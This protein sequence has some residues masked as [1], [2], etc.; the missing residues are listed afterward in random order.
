MKIF[1]N[2]QIY[3]GNEITAQ[4]NNITFID[5][6]EHTGVQIFEW[7][8]KRMQG[9]QV[10]IHVFCGIGNNGGNGLVVARH[11]INHGYNV[12]TYVVNHSKTRSKNFLVNYDRI[13]NTK[14]WPVL[15]D[16]TS[17][18]PTIEQPDIII[19][20]VFGIGLNRKIDGWVKSIFA[21][22]HVSR[23]F[24]LS[25][26]I[27]SGLFTDKQPEGEDAV[28]KANYTL[29]FQSPKLV[30]FLPETAKYTIEWEVLD[31]GIDREYLFTTETEAELLGKYEM[32]P[33][34]KHRDRFSHKGLFGHAIILGGSYGKIGAVSLASRAALSIGAGKVTA[35]VPKCGYT[36][37]QTALPEAMVI[38]DANEEEITAIDFD[39]TPSVIGLG[40]GMGTSEATTKA[41]KAFLEKNE[42]PL[43]VDADALNILSENTALLKLL[44]SQTI[45][46]PHPTELERLIGEWDNDF[47]KL[48]KTKA[49]SKKYDVIV[50][51][52]GGN[53]IT[54]Y[55]DKLYVNA[56]GNPGLAKAGTG[57]VLTGVITG[58]VAQ[59]YPMLQASIFGVYLHGRSADIMSRHTGFQSMM[60]TDVIEGLADA[61]LDL[62]AKPEQQQAQ[63]QENNQE[64]T[65]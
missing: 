59:Q 34:Y 30:F 22:L 40:V 61:Y 7:L 39:I 8:H 5:L 35:Y 27:P 33:L 25:V 18:L 52:K 57:D 1:T 2:T 10:P 12:N 9:A 44:P 63:E 17:E 41:L 21:H 46:T 37:L 32:Q 19:D 65:N 36:I 6:M 11:L 48:E 53:S 50:V 38:T 58:L 43:V 14:S 56:S 55:G 28:V 26:D 60:P 13:K 4:K 62:F 20:A 16:E 42:A 64:Q 24:V 47:D 23:A 51:I 49:F 15:L 3:T 29:S 31:V 54:V 45:L